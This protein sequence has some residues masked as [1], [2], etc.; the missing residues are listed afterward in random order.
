M[1]MRPPLSR[2]AAAREFNQPARASQME[3][4]ST[5]RRRHDDDDDDD[6]GGSG[7]GGA[8]R[9]AASASAPL[10]RNEAAPLASRLS[11]PAK[12]APVR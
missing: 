6:D 3:T 1:M 11:A 12:L 2:L 10:D 4:N 9:S 7:G 8:I 5:R